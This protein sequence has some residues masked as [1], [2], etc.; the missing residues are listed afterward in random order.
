VTGPAA[1]QQSKGLWQIVVEAPDAGAAQAVIAALD[2]QGGAVSAF[3]SSPGGSWR[4]DALSL[5]APDRGLIQARL[6][7]AWSG[8]EGSPPEPVFARV[9]QQDWLTANQASF[10]PITAGRFLIHGSHFTGPFPSGSLALKIDAATAFGTGEH[11]STQGCLWALDLLARRI[12]APRRILDLGTGTGVLALAASRLWRRPVSAFDIDAEAI[13]VARRNA[14]VNGVAGLVRARRAA[15]YRNRELWQRAPYDLVLANILARPLAKMARD[16]ARA[17]SPR[18]AAVLA[19]LL[20][21]QE[22]F[23]LSAH[24][25]AGLHLVARLDVSGWRCLVLARAPL[26][27]FNRPVT[28]NGRKS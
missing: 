26:H 18:G 1:E 16:L 8:L 6:A 5:D 10:P 2:G 20:P 12:R 17:L 25:L 14:R 11:G 24:R 13:R 4:I 22:S 28:I 19:G 23:V 3:E 27:S 21:R 9:A 15:G 7:L